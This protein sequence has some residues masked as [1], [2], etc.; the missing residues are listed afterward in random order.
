MRAVVIA[1]VLC[2]CS[3]VV[4]ADESSDQSSIFDPDSFEIK[5]EGHAQIYYDPSANEGIY[6]RAFITSLTLSASETL[7]FAA[8]KLI[9]GGEPK[10][11]TPLERMLRSL[12]SALP[13]LLLEIPITGASHEYG[14]FRGFSVAGMNDPVF[15]S[16]DGS[17][18]DYFADPGIAIREIA[19]QPFTPGEFLFASQTQK[20]FLKF[21]EDPK[22]Q[23]YEAYYNSLIA[24]DGLNQGQY[25]AEMVGL[26]MLRG[27]AHP[28]D[29]ITF[30]VSSAETVMYS[31]GGG[32]DS[33]GDDI[34]MYIADLGR[35][36]VKTSKSQIRST[37]QIPK[38]LSNSTVSFVVAWFDYWI[39]GDDA[40]EP[41][42]L[43]LGDFRIN[44]PDFYS[45]LTLHGPT[46]KGVERVSWRNYAM[47]ISYERSL[48]D[49]SQEVGLMLE[50]NIFR[51]LS[52]SA[53]GVRNFS[54][55]GTW[56]EAEVALRPLALFGEAPSAGSGQADPLRW[57]EVGAKGYYGQ[58]DTF[59]REIVG[60]SLHFEED[61]TS[62]V[63]WFIGVNI[64][65]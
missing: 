36:G 51:W 60:P 5:P 7:H 37:S 62:G 46:I 16:S 52:V 44:W 35:A 57:L 41:L 64:P 47:H 4:F 63:K 32:D 55:G 9:W 49:G 43:E 15:G 54:T 28:L 33:G 10:K 25:N 53:E 3:P 30:F 27:K 23:R 19:L 31:M 56:A 1:V 24:G 38:L 29:A 8:G 58:G 12:G 65:F 48:A 26:K 11:Q 20:E 6:D 2:C 13:L 50:G 40:V 22:R 59:R 61:S 14:H 39:T 45:Y 34:S 21:Q 17:K 18:V 42:A